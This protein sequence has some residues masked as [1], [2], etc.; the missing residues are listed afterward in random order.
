MN[1]KVFITGGTIDGYEYSSEENT[2]EEKQSF[3][4]RLLE[5]LNLNITYSTKSLMNK[6]SRFITDED[7]KIIA[8]KCK[9]SEE[10]KI[11]ITHGTITMVETAK[12]LKEKDLN[13]TIVLTGAMVPADQEGTD[14]PDNLKLS[15]EEI[16]KLKPGVYISMS[17]KIFEAGNVRKNTEKGVFEELSS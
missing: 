16:Q 7:R 12:Y 14:A 1:I 2:P 3:I 5:S 9:E 17:G 15:F 13:K 11:I 8:Q 10:K 6:D 4:P